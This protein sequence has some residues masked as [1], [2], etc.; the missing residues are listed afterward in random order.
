[1]NNPSLL[2]REKEKVFVAIYIWC[3]LCKNKGLIQNKELDSYHRGQSKFACSWNN[4]ILKIKIPTPEVSRNPKTCIY[5]GV[6]LPKY[7]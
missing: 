1:M 7:Q 2:L 3:S 5:M 6:M 4:I